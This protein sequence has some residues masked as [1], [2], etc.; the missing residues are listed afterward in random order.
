MNVCII[1]RGGVVVFS[2]LV[3]DVVVAFLPFSGRENI[4]PFCPFCS[5]LGHSMPGSASCLPIQLI[6]VQLDGTHKSCLVLIPHVPTAIFAFLLQHNISSPK[7]E[8]PSSEN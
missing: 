3:G 4:I 2:S 8:P 1:T 6:G 5:A 7:T